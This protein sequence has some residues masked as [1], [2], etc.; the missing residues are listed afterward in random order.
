MYTVTRNTKYDFSGQS[1]STSYPN[2]HKYP[3]TMIP[4]IGI[5]I[6]KELKI[7][8]GN[9]L[10]PYCGSGSSFVV[11]LER[12]LK[13]MYGYDINPLAIL[14]S[15]AKFTKVSFKK[16]KLL[17]EEIQNR[18]FEL[19][20]NDDKLNDIES[21][22][23]Y[24]IKFWFSEKVLKQLSIIKYY[25]DKIDDKNL[26]R[27]F[28]VAFSETTRESSYTRNGEFKLY[29]MKEEDMKRFN[30]DVYN[31][32][33]DKLRK[34][35]TSYEKYYYPLLNNSKIIIDFRHFPKSQNYFDIVL[36]SP[37]YGDSKTTVA[38]GQFS[39]FSN[40][41]FGIKDAR[42]IDQLLMGG[43]TKKTIYQKGLI[44]DYIKKI[45]KSSP[46]RALEVSSF[47]EDLE[48]SIN[49]VSISVKPGGK[50]IY[51][52]GNRTVKD[53]NLPTDQFIAE[54]FEK[55]NFKH[56]VTYERALGNKAMPSLNSPTNVT[57]IKRSTMTKEYIIVCEKAKT[58]KSLQVS[59]KPIKPYSSKIQTNSN[60]RSDPF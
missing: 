35:I 5:E 14:I 36:T 13:V 33:L 19:R 18:L 58:S 47:Y 12:G 41:W 46:K 52:I 31:I 39:L 27:L 48:S 32:Y 2:L 15:R 34:A 26:R 59:E 56:L 42:K 57:G 25:I 1:Y 9:L 16:L 4:Q 40:E 49:D 60:Y 55:N 28:Y 37:P 10:D 53:V 43:K 3:A 45:E 6:F 51:I 29:R 44:V 7:N 21:P 24:N 17:Y 38:Y 54:K 11:G 23:F 8:K 50:I 30:P 22:N 20:F